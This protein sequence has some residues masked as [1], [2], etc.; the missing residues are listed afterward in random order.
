MLRGNK[1]H[2]QATAQARFVGALDRWFAGPGVC[3]VGNIVR[4]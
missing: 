1:A 3:P 2:R 4:G